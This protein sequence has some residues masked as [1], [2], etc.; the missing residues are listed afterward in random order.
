MR[1]DLESESILADRV[2]QT[3]CLQRPELTSDIYRKLEQEQKSRETDL[4]SDSVLCSV[5]RLDLEYDSIL[6][7]RDVWICSLEQP[8]V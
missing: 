2:D 7:Y 4:E 5:V 1:L 3:C 8:R 6:I